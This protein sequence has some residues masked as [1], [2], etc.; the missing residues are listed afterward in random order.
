MIRKRKSFRKD[1]VRSIS[2]YYDLYPIRNPLS[3]PGEYVM[4]GFKEPFTYDFSYVKSDIVPITT[5]SVTTINYDP[6]L[7]SNF[8]ILEAIIKHIE[9]RYSISVN[10]DGLSQVARIILFYDRQGSPNV[11]TLSLFLQTANVLSPVTT[12]SSKR[13]LVLMDRVYDLSKFD[14]PGSTKFDSFVKFVRLP[15]QFDGIDWVI[16]RLGSLYLITIGTKTGLPGSEASTL[17]YSIRMC[18][19]QKTPSEI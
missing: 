19:D 9:L 5:G 4:D 12:D 16:P 11:F 14:Q 8:V 6:H 10:V 2:R 18:H 15:V 1:Y 13:Y 7:N 3:L 17:Q